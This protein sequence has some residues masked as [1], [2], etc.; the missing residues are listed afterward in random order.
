[1]GRKGVHPPCFAKSGEVVWNQYLEDLQKTGVCRR[2]K[3]KGLRTC[4]RGRKRFAVRKGRSS[5]RTRIT[6][7]RVLVNN[8]LLDGNSNG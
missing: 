6:R 3:R 4:V 2:L 1:M 7:G 8:D 5:S